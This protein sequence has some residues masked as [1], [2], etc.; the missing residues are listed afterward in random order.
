MKKILMHKDTPVCQFILSAS[1]KVGNV[2]VLDNDLFPWSGQSEANCLSRW[3][4]LR[5][6]SPNRK[7]LAQIASFYGP[8][9]KNTDNLCSL[10]DCYWIKDEGG[11]L[12]WD[13]ISPFNINDFTQDGLYLA[14][15]KPTKFRSFTENSPNLT[16]PGQNQLFWH[17]EN[18]YTGLINSDA[19][20]DMNRYKHALAEG[21]TIFKP[22]EYII[23]SSVIYT[24]VKTQTSP[25]VERIPF[26]QL[27]HEAED[28]NFSMTEN[29]KRCCKINNIPGW[30]DF[31]RQLILFN[32]SSQDDKIELSDIGVLRNSETL[33]YI[34]FDKL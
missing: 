21:L 25:E 13:D 18:G 23:I 31:I 29:L 17:I 34:G 19:Q 33:E 27:F 3:M 26:D 5:K 32:K 14:V 11:K 1:G 16:I 6:T 8:I 9:I 15:V 28:K 7:D 10:F 30:E 2:K 20:L 4:L 24:F 12:T 22:R